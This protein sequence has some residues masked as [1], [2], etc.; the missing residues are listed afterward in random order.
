MDTNSNTPMSRPDLLSQ[1]Q[2]SPLPTDVQPNNQNAATQVLTDVQCLICLEDISTPVDVDDNTDNSLRPI[3]GNESIACPVCNKITHVSCLAVWFDKPL[4]EDL[5][6][7]CRKEVSDDFILEVFTLFKGQEAATAILQ[8]KEQ[9]KQELQE[10]RWSFPNHWR[11]VIF[12]ASQEFG[13]HSPTDETASEDERR[14]SDEEDNIYL[15]DLT[16]WGEYRDPPGWTVP[17]D[18]RHHQDDV[19]GAP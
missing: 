18:E 3:N 2:T 7:H 6:P 4:T 13:L 5:C 14:S 1:T 16:T 19:W 17:E 8:R 11:Q 15:D 12:Y 9:E 10:L